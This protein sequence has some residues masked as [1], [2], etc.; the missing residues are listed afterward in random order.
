MTGGS[1]RLTGLRATVHQ[2][3]NLKITVLVPSLHPLSLLTKLQ[4]WRAKHCC[5]SCVHFYKSLV[6]LNHFGTAG[7]GQLDTLR[8][9]NP[10]LCVLA[11]GCAFM[12][13]GQNC[14]ES[15]GICILQWHHRSGSHSY[16]PHHC[17]IHH[18]VPRSMTLITLAVCSM[19]PNLLFS[20]EGGPAP[21][22][23]CKMLH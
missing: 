15:P 7:M 9:H 19:P 14:T 2:R 21:F 10:V 12:T 4:S 22:I 13:G 23:S 17:A 6:A 5:S 11:Y 18:P 1:D 8:A 20:T 3:I 16:A